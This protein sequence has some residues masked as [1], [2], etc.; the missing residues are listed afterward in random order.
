[1]SDARERGGAF[2]GPPSFPLFAWSSLPTMPPSSPGHRREP[3][4]LLSYA[5][6]LNLNDDEEAGEDDDGRHGEGHFHYFHFFVV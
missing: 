5:D 2:T 6:A 4:D 1:M 3:D